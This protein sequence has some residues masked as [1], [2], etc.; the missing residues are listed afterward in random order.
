MA[1]IDA[2][3]G[4]DWIFSGAGASN[5]IGGSGRDFVSYALMDATES[6]VTL[7]LLD[8]SNNSGYAIG[9]TFDGI[10]QIEGSNNADTFIFDGPIQKLNAR[11]GDDTIIDHS[12][13]THLWGGTGADTFVS[14]EGAGRANIRG[15]ST[16]EGDLID[17]S[18]W[19]ETG[20][21][22]A[23][24]EVARRY[25]K[26]SSKYDTDAV[27][28]LLDDEGQRL[29][30]VVVNHVSWDSNGNYSLSESDFIFA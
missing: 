10:E 4:N 30:G 7:D 14:R 8:A 11:G 18:E 29:D 12:G 19:G 20:L 22:D 27:L 1:V 17:M 2:G 26:G 3:D 16:V 15:F 6:G 28:L 24:F 25:S 23:S 13:N 21:D 5:N 9:D